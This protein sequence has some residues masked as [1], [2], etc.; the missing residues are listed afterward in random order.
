MYITADKSGAVFMAE[1]DPRDLRRAWF[2]ICQ[3]FKT[4]SEKEVNVTEM[5]DLLLEVT[6]ITVTEE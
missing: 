3:L 5:V 2:K 6:T 4:T 1:D